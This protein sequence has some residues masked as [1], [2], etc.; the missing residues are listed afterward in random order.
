MQ[1]GARC[2][3]FVLA[4]LDGTCPLVESTGMLSPRAPGKAGS[5]EGTFGRRN[6]G[7]DFSS[8]SSDFKALGALFCNFA[9]F[10][11]LRLVS[12]SRARSAARPCT[13]SCGFEASET[14]PIPGT[15]SIF[16]SRCGAISGRLRFAVGRDPSDRN[17]SV[18]KI[19]DRLDDLRRDGG[20]RTKIERLRNF[21]KKFVE[22]LVSNGRGVVGDALFAPP[23]RG[24]KGRA[25]QSENPAMRRRQ[26]GDP[27]F[28]T[29]CV[30]CKR[31][32]RFGA[33]RAPSRFE[34]FRRRLRA[35]PAT[36]ISRCFPPFSC[37]AHACRRRLTRL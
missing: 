37:S 33:S 19:G 24:H 27:E 29:E 7:A 6:T 9:T 11:F 35:T 17:A 21:G 3:W 32:F 8:A 2:A 31:G 12:R 30:L 25:N 1:S 36:G 15:D 5:T 16:S 34:R 14:I 20:T 22:R 13:T 26:V 4:A 23:K 18:Q 28:F 10:S